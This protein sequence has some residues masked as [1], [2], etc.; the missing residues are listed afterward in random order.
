M[1]KDFRKRDYIIFFVIALLG[2]IVNLTSDTGSALFWAVVKS[3][4]ASL[5]V[6]GV[7]GTL[8]NVIFRKRR[9]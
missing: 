8:T 4:I 5:V 2:L 3:L 6:S 9:T 1:L 7:L